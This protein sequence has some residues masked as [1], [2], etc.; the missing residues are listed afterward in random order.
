MCGFVLSNFE[1][2]FKKNSKVIRH[3]GPDQTGNYKD[4]YINILF[5]RL[6]IIDLNKRSDQPFRYKNYILVFNG[7]IYNYLELKEE[8]VQAGYKFKTKS[9]TEVLLFSFIHWKEKCLK[10][11]EGM[12]AFCVYDILRKTIFVARDRFGIKPIFYYKDDNRFVVSSEKKSIFEL[13]IEK[14]LNVDAM[15]NFILRGVYQNDKNTFFKKIYSLEPG[16]YLKIKNK[17]F[18]I[19]KWFEL[20]VKKE[21]I[22]YEDAKIKLDHLIKKS[23]RLSLRSDKNIAVSVSGGVDS[24]TLIYKLIETGDDNKIKYLVHWTCNDE[25]DEKKFA[26]KLAKKFKKKLLISNFRKKDYFS[27]L[28]K[29]LNIIEEPFGGLSLMS[30]LKTFENLKQKKIRVLLDGNGIDEILGGYNHHIS[31]H[32]KNFLDYGNQPVQG[33]KI[34]FPQDIL[35]KKWLDNLPNFKIQKKFSNPLR[36][37]MYNDLTGSKLRR[38]LL[39]GDHLTMSQSIETRYPFLNNELVSFCFSLP[40]EYL[41]KNDYGKYIL[42]D[43]LNERIF[44]DHKRPN[45]DPQT[46]WMHEFVLDRFVKELEKEEDF[47]DL[48]IFDKYHLLRR[49]KQWKSNKTSNSA[50]PM[51]MLLGFKFI[52][53]NFT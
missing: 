27:Y 38:V 25:N 2:D 42:R 53:K 1:F 32:E 26:K 52:K 51:Y 6:S 39:Q 20:E 46:K 7:E 18:E 28:K 41:I 19:Q 35:K 14:K 30:S 48:G 10:K 50:F 13:D 36:D 15:S 12:F 49:L 45:Q 5:N 44:W 43:L 40:N 34:N 8:L 29:V 23:L 47:F 16:K 3:R 24:S 33:L 21:K 31:A 11:L 17:K 4:N 9:D 37:S 22:D